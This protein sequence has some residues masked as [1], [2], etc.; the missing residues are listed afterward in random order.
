MNAKTSKRPR[1]GASRR[2][3]ALIIVLCFIVLLSALVVAFFTQATSYRNLSS[4]SVN[5]FK[6]ESLAQSALSVIVGDLRQEIE[7]GS[8]KVT[9]QDQ[10][11][12]FPSKNINAVPQR[13]GDIAAIPNLI[14][15]SIASDPITSPGI[16]SRASLSSSATAA[17]GGRAVTKSRWNAHYLI[18][19]ANTAGTE[20]I[21]DFVAPDWVYVTE[22]GPE[23]ITTAG[24]TVL[25]RYAYAVYDEGGL[26]DANAAGFPSGTPILASHP[27]PDTYD[28]L[29][30]GYG[31]KRSMGAA[32]LL[33]L[34]LTQQQVD[35]VLGWRTYA[36]AA[37]EGS[38]PDFTFNAT[39]AVKYHDN[40]VFPEEGGLSVPPIERGNRTDQQFSSRQQLIELWQRLSLPMDSLQYFGTFSRDLDQPSFV[41]NPNRPKVRASNM[42]NMATWGSGNDA[43]GLDREAAGSE[44][45]DINPPILAVRVTTPF[46]RPDG[47]N[48]EKGEPLMKH[49]FPL[50]RLKLLTRTA[51]A[52]KGSAD[53]IYRYFGLFRSSQH[54]PWQYD[55]GDSLG[56]MRL[57]EV[58]DAGREPDFFEILKAGIN[59]GS[60]AKPGWQGRDFSFIREQYLKDGLTALHTLEIGANIIDQYDSDGFV[61]R[62]SFAGDLLKEV[63]GREDLPYIYHIRDRFV[64]PTA[65]V[66]VGRLLMHPVL[67][68]PHDPA[69]GTPSAAP[70]EFRVRARTVD[71]SQSLSFSPTYQGNVPVPQEGALWETDE[72]GTNVI[73]FRAGE[74][75]GYWGFRQPTLLSQEKVPATAHTGGNVLTQTLTD[76]GLAVVG[77]AAADFPLKIPNPDPTKTGNLYL[78]IFRYN[79]PAASPGV[80]YITEY[81]DGADW[82][83]YGSFISVPEGSSH[84]V[85]FF[86][87]GVKNDTTAKDI[88]ASDFGAKDG[89]D[90]IDRKYPSNANWRFWGSSRIDPRTSRWGTYT[91]QYSNHLPIISTTDK[92]YSTVREGT[93]LSYANHHAPNTST[94]NPRMDFGF[95]GPY[96]TYSSKTWYRG[97]QAGYWAENSVRKTRQDATESETRRFNRDPDGV[98]RR[99]MGGYATDEVQGGSLDNLKGLPYA[100]DNFASRPLILNRP[101]RSVAE[102]GYVYTGLPWKNL[103]MSVPESGATALLDLFSAEEDED[104]QEALVAGRT[105][106]NT[107]QSKVLQAL[108]K[109]AMYDPED[110]ASRVDGPVAEALADALVSRTSDLVAGNRR[111]PVANRAELVGAYNPVA[112]VTLDTVPD[113]DSYYSG[114]SYDIGKVAG[115]KGLDAALI[116]RKREAAIRALNEVGTG[117]TWNLLIDVVAQSGRFTTM[118]GTNLDKFT[119]EGEK[120]YWL[121]VAIDRYTGEILDRKLEPVVE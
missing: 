109:D 22:N 58:A 119:I 73:T 98:P 41:P 81:K 6:A 3:A 55:H 56:I 92:T 96:A 37:P 30:W 111:G 118:A 89:V 104:R 97:F 67:W 99:A 93:E 34:G 28:L 26:L 39:A 117:R 53:P 8:T 13:S 70:A 12:F 116:S 101:F 80:E 48:A 85:K 2:G 102:L 106:L 24:K 113:P 108:L 71:S 49:R 79:G 112:G 10:K 115:V 76:P 5:E 121:H 68:N 57:H 33:G 18:P 46:T 11:L 60:L 14:R 29:K 19:R 32:N 38:F 45:K 63:C 78:D 7:A 120:R 107:R 43:F 100:M 54:E 65:S 52:A 110:T 74:S 16:G 90:A 95:V 15:R 35:K 27:A 21:A 31:L 88:I 84:S 36:S 64:F 25:G 83:Q 91:F 4:S 50:S 94:S 47:T 20:P 61:T 40:S 82:V 17:L 86:H 1:A 77:L 44:Y 105:N 9:V 87:S 59:V 62:I 23:V 103:N 69:S 51:V 66:T 72:T 42:S 75:G 114:F